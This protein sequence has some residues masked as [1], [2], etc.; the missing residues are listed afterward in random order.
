MCDLKFVAFLLSVSCL[1]WSLL[2][3]YYELAGWTG[4]RAALQ[5]RFCLCTVLQLLMKL[6]SLGYM[7]FPLYRPEE[8]RTLFG[9]YGPISDVYIPLDYYS[10]RPRGFAYVQYP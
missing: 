2:V 5:V 4:N 6:H 7:L 3:A 10:R 1:H 8:L 9:K